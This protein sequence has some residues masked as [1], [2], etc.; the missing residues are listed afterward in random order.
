MKL[1]ED[2]KVKDCKVWERLTLLDTGVTQHGS[3][4]SG[5]EGHNATAKKKVDDLEVRNWEQKWGLQCIIDESAEVVEK[6]RGIIICQWH[7]WSSDSEF[8]SQLGVIEYTGM[9]GGSET[10]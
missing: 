4:A 3:M 5:E 7:C 9:W 2:E 10:F 8:W 6:D 1:T